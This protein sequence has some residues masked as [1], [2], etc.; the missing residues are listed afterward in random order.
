MA[1]DINL[2]PARIVRAAINTTPNNEHRFT[3][4]GTLQ[5]MNS[6][7][8][9][10]LKTAMSPRVASEDNRLSWR[11]GT[12]RHDAIPV[13]RLNYRKQYSTG[14]TRSV[15]TVGGGGAGLSAPNEVDVEYNNYKEYPLEFKTLDFSI[16][17]PAAKAYEAAEAANVS[18]G[19]NEIA[20]L[21]EVRDEVLLTIEKDLLEPINSSCVTALIAGVGTNK[22]TNSAVPKNIVLYGADGRIRKDFL[23]YLGSLAQ[24]HGM[25]GKWIVIGGLTLTNFMKDA[26]IMGINDAGLDAGAMYSKLP[27]EHYYD[28]AIDILYGQDKILI[29]DPGS[30]AYQAILEHGAFGIVKQKEVANTTFDTGSIAIS[31]FNSPTFQLPIDVRVRAYD[32]EKYPF[33]EVILSS[34]LFGLFTRPAGFF[35]TYDGWQTYTGIIGAKLLERE[36]VTV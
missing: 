5:A 1:N 23:R 9:A 8:L 20:G 33:W 3:Q 35:K 13:V 4:V 21:A 2:A 6:P 29:I 11:P 32:T 19:D 17:E 27:I 26:E 14:G 22:V 18:L 36:P 16:L 31:Q 7:Q 30:A 12:G 15:R 10:K 24:V 34:G 28:P 25:T